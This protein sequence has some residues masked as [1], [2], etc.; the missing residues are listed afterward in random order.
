MKISI[1]AAVARNNVIGQNNGLPWH[2]PADLRHFKRITLGRYLLMG[3]KTFESLDGPLQNRTIVVISRR[4]EYAPEGVLKAHSLP[5]A[6]ELAEGEEEVFIAGGAEIYSEALNL[7]DCMYL[8]L[9]HQ[10]FEGD[11][12]FPE[13]DQDDWTL[14]DRTDHEIDRENPYPYS[15]L[16]YERN[17]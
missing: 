15:F 2:L 10:E 8:T 1:I 13:F 12:Y 4:P 14:I 11:T 7:A 3:R 5:D 17:C 9:I 6:I 16:T